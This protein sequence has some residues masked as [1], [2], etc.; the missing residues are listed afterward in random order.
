MSGY[1]L[2]HGLKSRASEHK[3]TASGGLKPG[4]DLP[5]NCYSGMFEVFKA[6]GVIV[7]PRS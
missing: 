5:P 2:P 1:S 7:L 3:M 6:A 4:P